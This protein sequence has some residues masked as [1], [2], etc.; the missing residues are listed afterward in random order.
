MELPAKIKKIIF[1]KRKI[2]VIDIPLERED[3]KAWIGIY[4]FP[5]H[6]D[7]EL[8]GI[9]IRYFEVEKYLIDKGYDI[10]ENELLNSVKICAKNEH[11]LIEF[12][13]KYIGDEFDRIVSPDLS[14][15]PI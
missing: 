2:M 15:Y 14:D 7:R 4:P 11:E 9:N 12:L 13:Y 6:N 3:R 10:A 8:E 5:H 1:E